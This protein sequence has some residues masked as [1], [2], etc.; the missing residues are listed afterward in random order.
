ML[1]W[2]IVKF[3]PHIEESQVSLI[4]EWQH[5][6]FMVLYLEGEDAL[7]VRIANCYVY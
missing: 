7:D 1:A 3:F 6:Q 2:P 5:V 4:S